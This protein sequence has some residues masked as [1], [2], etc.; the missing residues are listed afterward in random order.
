MSLPSARRIFYLALLPAF[1]LLSCQKET[2]VLLNQN[3]NLKPPVVDAG[4]SQVIQLPATTFT[5]TG[6]ATSTNGSIKAYLWSMISGPNVPSINSP[7]SKI[8]TVT[9]FISG[10]YLFQLMA[11]DSAGLTG[12]DTTSVRL[13]PA[14]IQTLTLQPANNSNEIH[15]GIIGSTPGSDP[16][17]PELV[18]AAWTTGGA[19]TLFR[20]AFKFDL[21]SIP[22]TATI[23]TA[24]LTLYSNPT[25]LNGNL[26]DANSGPNNAMYIN[27]ITGSW[28]AAS[29]N[30][31]SQPSVSTTDRISIAHTNL[32]LL[33]LT[34]VDVRTQVAAMVSG[35][36]NGFMIQL[37]NEVIYNIRDFCGSRYSNAA[38]HPKLVITY[39]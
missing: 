28:T 16:A 24:K 33:D 6:S 5:L 11:T 13:N 29:M 35:T 20:G 22:S 2:G 12:V 8:T 10:T 26:V 9:G 18:A 39:Q 30:W 27:R 14:P 17:A 23:L 3:S 32:S 7:G 37:Q 25:P 4:N 38:K 31:F 1:I 15:Y 36:N 19:L 34:D 21:S